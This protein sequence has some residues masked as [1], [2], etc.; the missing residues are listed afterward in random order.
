MK[1]AL[2]Q[3]RRIQARS[4]HLISEPKLPV[5]TISN[6]LSPF[7]TKRLELI[8]INANQVRKSLLFNIQGEDAD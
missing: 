2:E 7:Y 6:S 5:G 3:N 8:R 4:L 1:R